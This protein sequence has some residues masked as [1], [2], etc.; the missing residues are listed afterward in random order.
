MGSCWYL[1]QDVLHAQAP[2]D[3]EGKDYAVRCWVGAVLGVRGGNRRERL[4]QM[5]RW[6]LNQARWG[7]SVAIHPVIFL[8]FFAPRLAYLRLPER[9]ADDVC[10]AIWQVYAQGDT[11]VV[12]LAPGWRH[13]LRPYFE[14]LEL[15]DNDKVTSL[16]AWLRSIGDWRMSCRLDCAL[17]EPDAR[18][19]FAADWS[20]TARPKA[21]TSFAENL[22]GT[23][24]V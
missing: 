10:D 7:G 1:V 14:R 15:V 13:K 22:A 19:G 16:L 12:L 3:D 8:S 18:L 17:R 9:Y 5:M 20:S 23:L 24:P 21:A 2:D 11:G 4:Q 6:D